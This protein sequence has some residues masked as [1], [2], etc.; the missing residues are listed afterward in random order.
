MTHDTLTARLATRVTPR[1]QSAFQRK[2]RRHGRP[3]D[4]LRELVSA[5]IEGRLNVIPPHSKRIL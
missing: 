2:A 1:M 4:V 5:F 3:S